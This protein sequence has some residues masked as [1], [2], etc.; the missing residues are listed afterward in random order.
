MSVD[1]DVRPGTGPDFDPDDRSSNP[2]GNRP[3]REVL[4]ARVSRREVLRGGTVVAAA[5]FLGAA[6]ALGQA[7]PALAAP[8]T[9]SGRGGPLLG[10]TPVPTSSADAFTV[11]DGYTAEVLIPW[12]TPIRSSGPAWRKDASNTAAEQAEQIGM[13]HDGMH[14]FPLGP[15]RAGNRGGVLVLNHEYIDRPSCTPTATSS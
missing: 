8:S 5:G 9:A 6:G 1:R 2:S 12:G 4:A 15:G 14:Y 7:G 10:F 13:H 11:P 3:F